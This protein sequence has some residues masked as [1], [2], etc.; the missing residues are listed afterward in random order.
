MGA[1]GMQGKPGGGKGKQPIPM[2]KGGSMAG[3][4][5]PLTGLRGLLLPPCMVVW[6]EPLGLEAR[7]NC[8]AGV[9]VA[10]RVQHTIGAGAR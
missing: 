5:P 2:G 10:R 4:M 8:T 9:A 6:Q 7:S 3:C 1:M